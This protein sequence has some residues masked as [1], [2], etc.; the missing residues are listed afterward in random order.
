VEDVILLALLIVM[1]P[2][3]IM[4]LASP[5]IVLRHLAGIV[6]RHL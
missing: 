4:L 1:V 6:G 5:L 3:V 2:A